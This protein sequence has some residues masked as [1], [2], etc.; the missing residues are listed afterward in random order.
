M[1]E[2]QQ[3][4]SHAVVLGTRSHTPLEPRQPSTNNN[5]QQGSKHTSSKTQGVV[6]CWANRRLRAAELVGLVL[7]IHPPPLRNCNPPLAVLPC[8]ERT[9]R[10]NTD[11]GTTSTTQPPP[12]AA[13]RPEQAS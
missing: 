2:I 12:S 3:P 11:T 6:S 10:T 13:E 1:A 8:L 7:L 9:N 5:K 4:A